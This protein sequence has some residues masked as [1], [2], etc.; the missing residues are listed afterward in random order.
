[1]RA[2]NESTGKL[3][4]IFDCYVNVPNFGRI[5]MN[6]LPDITDSKSATYNDEAV[7][8]RATPIKTY[9][10][11]DNRP[12]GFKIH[13]YAT[14]SEESVKNLQILRAIQSC[15]YPRS[16]NSGGAPFAPPV[17]CTLK[18]GY[19]LSSQPICVVCK[20]YS[21]SFPTDVPWDEVTFAPIKFDIDTSWDVIYKSS[22]LPGQDKILNFFGA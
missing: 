19:L 16:D 3:V 8:G 13:L 12:I 17:I 21:V 6:S 5:Y 2:T 11:S 4:P 1:M 10:H 14:S 9:S 22:E 7:I 20:S 15:V 18:C